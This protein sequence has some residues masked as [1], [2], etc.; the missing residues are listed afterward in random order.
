M[1]NLS[2]SERRF[3][4]ENQQNLSQ[5]V[6]K[7]IRSIA[8]VRSALR[9]WETSRDALCCDDDEK[10]LRTCA[11]ASQLVLAIREFGRWKNSIDAISAKALTVGALAHLVAWSAIRNQGT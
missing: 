1:A 5:P 4:I 11:E 10:D 9:D 6:G 3:E 2:D 7:E 8:V